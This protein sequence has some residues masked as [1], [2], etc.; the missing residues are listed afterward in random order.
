MHLVHVEYVVRRS[1]QHFLAF[2]KNYSLQHVDRLGNIRHTNAAAVL[3][4]NVEG[5]TGNQRITDGVLLIEEAGIGSIL[6]SYQAP[7]HRQ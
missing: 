5:H 7:I 1:Q 6:T 3:M 2:R 4:E